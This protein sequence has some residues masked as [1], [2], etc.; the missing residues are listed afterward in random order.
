MKIEVVF[1]FRETVNNFVVLMLF[2]HLFLIIMY[3]IVLTFFLQRC[4]EMYKN[5][6][7]LLNY[8]FI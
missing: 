5:C 1:A 8:I 7:V 3:G 6:V 2:P 4:S